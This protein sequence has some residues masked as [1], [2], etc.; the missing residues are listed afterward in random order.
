MELF[1][2]DIR[3]MSQAEYDSAVAGM[4]NERRQQLSDAATDDDRRRMAACELLARQHM[5]GAAPA[6]DALGRI[7]TGQEGRYISAAASGAWA[8]CAVG[9]RPM[10][11]VVEVIRGAQEK[12][13]A[14][15][16]TEAEAHYVRYG[17]DGCF[18]R[19]W[20]CWTA[21]EALFKLTGK[22]PLLAL[23]A[24]DLPSD[25]ALDHVKDHGCTVVTAMRLG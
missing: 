16:L 3:T 11:T 18:A 7:T 2:Y 9:D 22:G 6:F 10:E 21:K 25:V 20:E 17:D 4:T 23:S 14:R 15:S 13:I 5:D 12:F 1:W 8:V 24:F 19:F